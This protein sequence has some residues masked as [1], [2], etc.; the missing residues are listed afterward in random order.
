VS[1]HLLAGWFATSGGGVLFAPSEPGNLYVY[2]EV[3]A[4]G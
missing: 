2:H 1:N 4:E 3:A